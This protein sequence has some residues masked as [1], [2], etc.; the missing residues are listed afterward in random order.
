MTNFNISV[1]F[2]LSCR[3]VLLKRS[4]NKAL[5]E[6][7]L[8]LLLG[9]RVLAVCPSMCTCSR[10][11]REVD[12][13]WRGLRLLPDGL[14]YNLHLS[15]NLLVR[16]LPGSLDRLPRLTHFYLQANRFTTMS[17][18][19]LDKL[20]SLRIIHLGSNP[21]ACHVPNEIAYIAY[22]AQQTSARV[23]GCPC[24]TQSI[25]GGVASESG[26]WYQPYTTQDYM[27]TP[28]YPIYPTF[29]TNN[30]LTLQTIEDFLDTDSYLHVTETSPISDTSDITDM[31]DVTLAANTY[32]TTEMCDSF[33]TCLCVVK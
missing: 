28:Y 24:H 11:H 5:L 26:K 25:C 4:P 32:F 27:T 22:W 16:V 10:S 6:L 31:A 1:S 20:T 3:N 9:W 19:V 18:G 17:F 29:S 15:N 21:W 23:L 30:K 2:I 7:L 14:Q 33:I 13:S 12:C 8:L